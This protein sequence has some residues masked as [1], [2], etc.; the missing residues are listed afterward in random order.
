M[1]FKRTALQCLVGAYA[2]TVLTLSGIRA[3]ERQL[4]AS[5]FLQLG[6]I[7][8]AGKSRPRHEISKERP[9]KTLVGLYV[10]FSVVG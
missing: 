10:L 5:A 1:E 9:P 2:L 4:I 7:L 8:G 6:T 3:S